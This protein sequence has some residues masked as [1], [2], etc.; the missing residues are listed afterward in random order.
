MLMKEVALHLGR[1]AG[2]F[3]SKPIK[4]LMISPVGLV[5]KSSPGEMRLNFDLSFPNGSSINE[6]ISREYAA[7]SYTSFDAVV[8]MVLKEDR[9]CSSLNI[10]VKSAFRFLPIHPSDFALRGMAEKTFVD[11]VS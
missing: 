9:G 8:D 5:P 7:V 4:D 3:F 2:P 11:K 10:D 6:G 1:V